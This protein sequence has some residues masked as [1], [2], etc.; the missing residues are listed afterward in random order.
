MPVTKSKDSFFSHDK[1]TNRRKAIGMHFHDEIELYYLV[2]GKTQ[3]VVGDK[4]FLL[5][6]NNLILLPAQI[7]HSCDSE[8]CLH[9]ERLLLSFSEKILDKNT[10]QLLRELE[11]D[12]L[13]V[14]PPDKL[15]L[16]DE[17][18]AR[19]EKEYQKERKHKQ[20]MLNL[21][22]AELITLLSRLKSDFLP[23]VAPT[24]KVIYDV[25]DYI[26]NHLD[27]PLLLE[28]LSHRFAISEGYLSR[29]FKAVTG[30]GL[31]AF[32]TQARII[33]AE[34]L[35]TETT[36]SISDV[37]GLCGFNDSNYFASVFKK[38]KGTTPYKF[39]KQQKL[40]KS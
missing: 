36:L 27:S 11:K 6:K 19:I 39:S 28:H 23:G 21:Y 5:E 10:L 32:I 22:V 37:A 14:I 17:L 13:I 12:N 16:I 31:N 9:N 25:V 29:K 1:V 38:L 3:Y 26:R 33:H 30:V 24:N 8:D 2:D 40:L 20:L 15:Y 18:F 4:I 34:K 35:L 7:L